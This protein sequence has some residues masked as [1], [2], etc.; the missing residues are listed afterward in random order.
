MFVDKNQRDWDQHLPMLLMA[1]RSDEHESTS[2]TPSRM[3]FG[4]ELRMPC[5]AL[6][7]RLEETFENTNEYISHVEERMLTIH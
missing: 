7:D 4:H 1:Y 6:L 5:D 3:F 2:Y